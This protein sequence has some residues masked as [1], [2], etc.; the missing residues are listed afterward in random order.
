VLVELWLDAGNT[1]LKWQ[2][3][4]AGEQVAKGAIVHKQ[5]MRRAVDSMF[6]ESQFTGAVEKEAVSVAGLASVLNEESNRVLAEAIKEKAGL[7]LQGAKVEKS[8][9]GLV[10]AYEDVGRLGVDR[11]LALLAAYSKY[12][13]AVCVISC[14]SALTVDVANKAGQHLGGYILPGLNMSVQSLLGSTHS[15]R[16]KKGQ[17]AGSLAYGCDTASAVNNGVLLQKVL[18]IK[19]VWERVSNSFSKESPKLVLTGGDAAFIRSHLCEMQ[20]IEICDDLVIQGLRLALQ[21]G[22]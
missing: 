18:F 2:L 5:D 12:E 20:E 17:E 6:Q 4:L 14:G 22:A 8:K 9:L 11:W 3:V 15:V 7:E 19:G 10:C 13:G 16:F 21:S 1:R